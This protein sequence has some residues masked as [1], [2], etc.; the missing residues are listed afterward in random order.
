MKQE[1]FCWFCNDSV[2]ECEHKTRE[3]KR[4]NKF[5]NWVNQGGKK[6]TYQKQVINNRYTEYGQGYRDAIQDVYHQ[7]TKTLKIRGLTECQN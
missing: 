6:N 1:Q 4:L 2:K 5:L 7:L 3:Q